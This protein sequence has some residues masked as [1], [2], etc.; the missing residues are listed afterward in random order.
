VNERRDDTGRVL[1]EQVVAPLVGLAVMYWAGTHAASI[2]IE[3]R[4]QWAKLKAY[5]RAGEQSGRKVAEWFVAM[6]APRVIAQAEELTRSAAERFSQAPGESP[7][8]S[9]EESE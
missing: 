6:H 4:A 9:G 7:S 2:E 8:G 1:F 3:L 5:H